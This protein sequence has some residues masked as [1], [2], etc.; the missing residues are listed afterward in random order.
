MKIGT[1]RRV[2]RVEPVES[3]VPHR[4]KTPRREPAPRPAKREPVPHK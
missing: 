3:P 2:Y 1:P 4:E